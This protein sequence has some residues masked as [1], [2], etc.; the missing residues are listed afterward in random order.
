[1]CLP[2]CLQITFQLKFFI[3]MFL[4]Y[5]FSYKNCLFVLYLFIYWVLMLLL[6]FCISCKIKIFLF[7]FCFLHIFSIVCLPFFKVYFF[8][9]TILYHQ[10]YMFSPLWLPLLPLGWETHPFKK[11]WLLF[12]SSFSM[13]WSIRSLFLIVK[14]FYKVFY[15]QR[16]SCNFLPE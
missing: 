14:Y 12:L 4:S 9:F 2:I 13:V 7:L 16:R 8:F 5:I 11:V 10:A 15:G 1:M 6:P 3:S